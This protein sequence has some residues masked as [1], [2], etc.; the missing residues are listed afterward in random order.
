MELKQTKIKKIDI[1]IS[2]ETLEY[3]YKLSKEKNVLEMGGRG[4]GNMIEEKYINEL[5]NYIF[6]SRN[7][8][9]KIII[10]VENEKIKF[11]KGE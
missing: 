9:G 10:Y 11:K 5:S 6:D 1:E 3:Y 2:Q 7:E 4:I 8:K